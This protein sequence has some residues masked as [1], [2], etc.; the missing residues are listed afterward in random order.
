MLQELPVGSVITVKHAGSYSN[1]TL[2]QP[3]F[4]RERDNSEESYRNLSTIE[5]QREFFDEIYKQLNL[6]KM[7]DWYKIS[8]EDIYNFGGKG[9]LEKTFSNSLFSALSNVYPHHSFN[10]KNFKKKI[11]PVKHREVFVNLSRRLN[12]QSMSDW[13]NISSNQLYEASFI[14][15]HYYRGSPARAVQEIFKEHEWLPWKFKQVQL[16]LWEDK[17]MQKKFFVWFGKFVGIQKMDEW[18]DIRVEDVCQQV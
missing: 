12:F 10:S 8:K 1:G 15:Q 5:N 7:D 18:Y 13:Y 14:V 11:D 17:E 4:W 16:G 6:S 9:L 2:K 3:V